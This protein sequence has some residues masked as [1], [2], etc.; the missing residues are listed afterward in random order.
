MAESNRGVLQTVGLCDPRL[1]RLRRDWGCDESEPPLSW[2]AQSLCFRIRHRLGVGDFKS[3]LLPAEGCVLTQEGRWWRRELGRARGT[4]TVNRQPAQLWVA[5]TSGLCSLP[6]PS[7]Q[8]DEDSQRSGSGTLR[9]QEGGRQPQSS[10]PHAIVRVGQRQL[11][12]VL[13]LLKAAQPISVYLGVQVQ[14]L[15]SSL[16]SSHLPGTL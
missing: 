7:F 13:K 15:P 2:F 9:A 4:A 1:L 14:V 12:G 8:A 16:G 5:V 6:Q 10:S 11:Q 3:L